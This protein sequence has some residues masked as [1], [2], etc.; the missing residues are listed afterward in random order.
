MVT[1]GWVY[2][3]VCYPTT[4]I[5]SYIISASVITL[6]TL[7]MAKAALSCTS[8]RQN[9]EKIWFVSLCRY[10]SVYVCEFKINLFSTVIIHIISVLLDKAPSL[11]NLIKYQILA[12]IKSSILLL[13]KVCNQYR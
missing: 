10:S 11:W 3:L 6:P 13:K 8:Q 2:S 9:H 4:P 5:I 1:P 12:D 7:T